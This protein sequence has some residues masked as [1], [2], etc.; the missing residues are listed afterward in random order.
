MN[1]IKFISMG[2]NLSE[3]KKFMEDFYPKFNNMY[4]RYNKYLDTF[5]ETAE[6]ELYKYT[7]LE[8]FGKR[9]KE[10]K[11]QLDKFVKMLRHQT[12]PISFNDIIAINKYVEFGIQ[13][14]NMLKRYDDDKM[15]GSGYSE[16]DM[17][18]KLN[19]VTDDFERALEHAQD[20]KKQYQ[21]TQYY[22]KINY[23]LDEIADEKCIILFKIL[24]YMN[25]SIKRSLYWDFDV[26]K[27]RIEYWVSQLDNCEETIVKQAKNEEDKVTIKKIRFLKK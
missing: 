9:L 27:M 17:R 2:S 8:I 24:D 10:I 14:E 11:K 25:D 19:T 4:N 22:K 21:D 23:F 12:R 15:R 26:K 18:E 13:F 16:E 5:K 7:I 6:N 1:S 3:V 20:V